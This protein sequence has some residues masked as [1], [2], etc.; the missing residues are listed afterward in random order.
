VLDTHEREAKA[1]MSWQNARE[2]FFSDSSDE[3]KE[4]ERATLAASDAEREARLLLLTLKP[5]VAIEPPV[6]RSA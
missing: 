5:N 1:T 2:N 4:H 3:R 6:L